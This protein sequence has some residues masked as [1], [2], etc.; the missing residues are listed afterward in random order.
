MSTTGKILIGALATTAAAWFLYGPLAHGARCIAEADAKLAAA[1]REL[2][3]TPN[4]EASPGSPSLGLGWRLDADDRGRRRW[5]HA[6]A[7]PGG[8]V[9]L[10]VYPGLDL[11]IALAGNVMAMMLDG[12]KAASDL[13]DIFA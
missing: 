11:S 1:E 13:A 3:F 9:V 2:L 6:G 5:H 12:M 7:T 4:T 10:V 8:R